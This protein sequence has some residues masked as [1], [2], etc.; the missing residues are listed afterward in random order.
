MVPFGRDE[1]A[2]F[3]TVKRG[4]KGAGFHLKDII[5]SGADVLGDGVPVGG[6][7]S[8]GSQDQQVKRPL[9]QFAA[10]HCIESLSNI[11]SIVYTTVASAP[12]Y[13]CRRD[14]FPPS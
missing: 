6:S 8:Q 9:E 2:F 12:P 13:R 3:Q 7:V 4:I 14:S 5:G 11:E 1:S 10:L